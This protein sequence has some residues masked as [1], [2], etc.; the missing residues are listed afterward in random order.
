MTKLNPILFLLF[1]VI[2]SCDK[3]NEKVIEKISNK[4][5]TEEIFFFPKYKFGDKKLDTLFLYVQLDDCGEWGGPKEDF[6]IY[7]NKEN[8][9]ILNYK[10]YIFDCDSIGKHYSLPQKLDYSRNIV[11][12]ENDKKLIRSYILNL[13]EQKIMEED[14]DHSAN[15]FVLKNQDSTLNIVLASSKIQ[16]RETFMKLKTKLKLMK[17][18]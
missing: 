8:S 3:H 18:K 9:Y 1:T 16:A 14:T 7:V 4:Q 2:F 15:Y 11:L 13:I 6:K 12:K 17:K 10:K 5:N